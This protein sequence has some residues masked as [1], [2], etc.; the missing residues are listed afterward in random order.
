MLFVSYRGWYAVSG[1]YQG[2]IGQREYFVLNAL[3]QFWIASSQ[4][5]GASDTLV[6]KGIAR[7]QKTL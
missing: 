6:E 4:Q 7:E 1:Q 5:I 2:L 3:Y